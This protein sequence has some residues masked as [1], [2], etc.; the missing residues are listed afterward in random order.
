M[1]YN[2]LDEVLELYFVQSG[3]FDVGYTI[4]AQKVFRIRYGSKN[5]IGAF[6][7]FF[8]VRSQ[9]AIRSSSKVQGFGY[10]KKNWQSL[11]ADYPEFEKQIII[12]V[13]NRYEK[14]I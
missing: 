2:E 4:N 1:I 11:M 13:H 3:T 9:V 5:V 7:I 8:G 12:Y 14:L 10:R 6:N